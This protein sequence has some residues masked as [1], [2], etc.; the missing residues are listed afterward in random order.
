VIAA[1]GRFERCVG[2]HISDLVDGSILQDIQQALTT[3]SSINRESY[4]VFGF[5]ANEHEC[6][7]LYM[8]GH[9]ELTEWEQRMLQLFCSNA[10]VALDNQRLYFQQRR[11]MT[12]ISRFVPTPILELLG[13]GAVTRIERGDHVAREMT[14]LFADLESFTGLAELLGPEQTFAFLNEF[15]TGLAPI[16]ARHGGVVDKYLGD[17]VMVLFPSGASSAV[18]AATD[19]LGWTRRFNAAGRW[20]RATRLGIGVDRGPLVLGMLGADERLDWTVIADCVNVASRLERMTRVFGV[21]LLVS[22]AVHQGLSAE[23]S[24]ES[25]PLGQVRVRGKSVAVGVFEVFAA[26]SEDA[27]ARKQETVSPLIEIC[28]H[29]RG[30]AL[31]RAQVR[32]A[33]LRAAFPGDPALVDLETRWGH[34]PSPL[35]AQAS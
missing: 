10:A 13:R 32:L 16:I 8:E 27:R 23:L 35:A 11:T 19:M 12:A 33:E 26:E 17:G 22:A 2:Q 15:Y 3:Q 6:A 29:T 5:C 4:S 1:T 31:E 25:R 14:V 7:A 18:A 30:G 34:H 24:A 20:P 28:A 9:G 21:D